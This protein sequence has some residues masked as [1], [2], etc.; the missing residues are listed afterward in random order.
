MQAAELGFERVERSRPMAI[1][2][3]ALPAQWLARARSGDRD[4]FGQLVGHYGPDVQRLCRRLLG[5]AVESEDASQESFARAHAALAATTRRG[6]SGAG[7]SRS[8]RTA[9]SM[10]CGGAG[11]RRGCSRARRIDA[12]ALRRS[13]PVAAPAR[14][15]RR[16]ARQLLA[17]IEAQPDLYRAPLAL[18]YFADLDYGE[19]AEILGVSRNQVATLL[20]RARARLREAL[21]EQLCDE[22]SEPGR[23]ACCTPRASSR[24][25][26]CARPRRIWCRAA[27]AARA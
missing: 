11:A 5:S 22:L 6:R 19:I 27:T 10:R 13:G 24:A 15:L 1:R 18:R 20:F 17:A 4:A 3:E 8:P 12:D 2:D 14:S 7:C 23:R 21:A 16:A 25:A 26:R 9:R